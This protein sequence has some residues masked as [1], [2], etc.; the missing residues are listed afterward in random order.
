MD[1]RNL[2][3]EVERGATSDEPLDRLTA[4]V[5]RHR[6]LTDQAD[7]LLDHFVIAARETGCS[8]A[9]VGEVLGV[10]K[11]A[12]QQRHGRWRLP[13]EL[14]RGVLGKRPGLFQR[15]T[16]RSRAAV[17]D[18]V[19]AA[20]QLGHVSIGTEHVLV[21]IL[22]QPDSVGAKVLARWGLTRDGVFAD[23][24]ERLGR[25]EP[26][27]SRRHIPFSPHAKKALELALRE[28]ISLGHNHIGTEHVLLGLIRVDDGAAAILRDHGVKLG[29]ARTAV[30]EELA[31]AEADDSDP[32]HSGE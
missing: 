3:A 23:V 10:T 7:Q 8:W 27:T 32:V 19:E 31:A 4:A 9:Q 24:A 1:V 20:R 14:L 18:G 22:G 29:D 6:E 28:S 12:A 21:G 15:F 5:T 11:Q 16:P 17:V 30:V 13:R 26:A 2:I 25:N